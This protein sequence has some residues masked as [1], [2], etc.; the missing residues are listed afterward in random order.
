MRIRMRIQVIKMT[1][2]HADPDAIWIHI[3]ISAYA[4]YEKSINSKMEVK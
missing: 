1:R 4:V 3:W 2:I